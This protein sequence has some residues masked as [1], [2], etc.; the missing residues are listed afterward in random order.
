[1][2]LALDP[3]GM[4]VA[5]DVV[6]GQ[7][8]DD[9]QSAQQAQQ[10]GFLV[11]RQAN[12]AADGVWRSSANEACKGRH[13]NPIGATIRHEMREL[14]AYFVITFSLIGFTEVLMLRE[15]GITV[16]TFVG[17][18]FGALLVAKAVLIIGVE[19]PRIVYTDLDTSFCKEVNEG[20][21]QGREHPRCPGH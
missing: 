1:M 4:P 17:A 19:C 6:P 14:I 11:S 21:V 3:L 16:S 13:M 7:R 5:T 12:G 2:V 9:P 15:Y 20:H 10:G 18:T 8:A